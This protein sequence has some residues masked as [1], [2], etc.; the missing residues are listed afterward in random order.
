MRNEKSARTSS[1]VHHFSF[2][3]EQRAGS[4]GEKILFVVVFVV[5]DETETE[6]PLS[7]SLCLSFSLERGD[8]TLKKKISKSSF[9]STN[10]NNTLHTYTHT[11]ILN[12]KEMNDAAAATFDAVSDGVS[13]V[14]DAVGKYLQFDANKAN[15]FVKLR[16]NLDVK[17]PGT[18][19]QRTLSRRFWFLVFGFRSF[20]LCLLC[21][22]VVL[23]ALVMNPSD[24]FTSLSVSSYFCA[25]GKKII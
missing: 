13:D 21:I 6:A 10:N 20:S 2:A 12:K 15:F 3:T 18:C 17:F 22:R 7:L 19:F 8:L 11:R 25:F 23:R 16:K 14:K 9:S 5:G 4:L 1:V 24:A